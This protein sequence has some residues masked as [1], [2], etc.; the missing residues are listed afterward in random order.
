V[1]YA[2]ATTN[3]Q[4]PDEDITRTYLKCKKDDHDFH[5]CPHASVAGRR[6]RKEQIQKDPIHETR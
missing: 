4:D 6:D 2:P 1:E 5:N 3:K